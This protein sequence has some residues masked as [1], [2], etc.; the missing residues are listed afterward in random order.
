MAT[1]QI[2]SGQVIDGTL[3][4]EDLSDAAGITPIKL[5]TINANVGTYGSASQVPQ[6]TV[7][8]KGQ[9]TAVA[10]VAVAVGLWT[11]VGFAAGNFTANAGTWT[12]TAGNV[13]TLAYTLIGK[14]MTVAFGLTGTSV[15]AAPVF[16]TITIPGGLVAARRI[17][18]TFAFIDNG[19]AG[20]GF[21]VVSP[22]GTVISLLKNAAG[23]AWTPSAA[24][25]QVEGQISFEIQ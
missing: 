14:T 20:T 6:V 15:S 25:T 3:V 12:V 1:M 22:G 8:A 5:A 2:R 11:A 21:A 9:I 18:G 23:T 19:V 7:N 4:N 17:G 16:L 24:N 13:L 10:N